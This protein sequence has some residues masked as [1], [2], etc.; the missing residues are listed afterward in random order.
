MTAAKTEVPKMEIDELL[1][2]PVSFPLL[3]A[4]R[5]HGLRR[6]TAY[7]LA[8]TGDFPCR[9]LKLGRELKVT[10]ADLFTS[11]GYPP[12]MISKSELKPQPKRSAA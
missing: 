5:A 6:S 10:R 11:L 4:A 12:D 8:R 9:V 3:T 2:L 7:N 1:A